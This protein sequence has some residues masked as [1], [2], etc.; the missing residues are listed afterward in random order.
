M[1]LTKVAIFS[2]VRIS[3]DA[4]VRASV[5]IPTRDNMIQLFV[6]K[7]K[8]I[9]IYRCLKVDIDRRESEVKFTF[10]FDIGLFKHQSLF[11]YFSL[12]SVWLLL[13]KKGSND[14]HSYQVFLH[15]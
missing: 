4:N 11:Y 13:T 7:E 6:F 3:K 14:A 9:K 1:L 10:Q 12:S 2:R 15:I 8:T 5:D